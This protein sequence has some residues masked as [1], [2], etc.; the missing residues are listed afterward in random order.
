MVP[1]RH[2]ELA[3]RG[4]C[5]E[6]IDLYGVGG[7]IP[8]R[9]LPFSHT[10]MRD[11]FRTRDGSSRGALTVDWGSYFWKSVRA[12]FATLAEEGSRKDEVAKAKASTPFR[13]GRF[14]FA[15]LR[16]KID[17]REVAS[18]SR[19][20]LRSLRAGDGVW[21]IHGVAKN[22]PRG[23]YFAA[24]PSFLAYR[25]DAERCACRELAELEIAAA[26]APS[27]RAT[28]PLFG[29]EP[30][31][32]FHHSQLD[33]ALQLLLACGAKVPEAELDNY[34]VHSFRV[35]AACALLAAD[36]PRWTIKRLLR[37]RGDDSLEIY[38]RLNDDEWASWIGK[39]L[40]VEVDSAIASRFTDMDFSPEVEQRFCEIASSLLAFGQ[41]EDAGEP[42][43]KAPTP[44]DQTAAPAI[45]GRAQARQAALAAAPKKGDHV[46]VDFE[47]EWWR[48]TAGVTRWSAADGA[49]VTRVAYDAARGWKAHTAWHVA[50]EFQWRHAARVAA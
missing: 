29:P 39:S 15:S 14:T 21:L 12:C 31:E 38:A 20:Q 11:M 34:S 42:V 40:T 22:D 17:G 36:C 50:G 23:A 1:L 7:L 46:E 43:A 25:P 33:R 6:Y 26:L 32:E 47:G 9:K 48:G 2:V 8:E 10:I 41:P 16:W 30:G 35:F 45:S 5:R 27:A 4:M 13:K 19:A 3:V 49:Y 44:T 24:T 18:P 28:T 37:W